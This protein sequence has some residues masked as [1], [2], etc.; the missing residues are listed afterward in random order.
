[1]ARL[2]THLLRQ[3]S[4]TCTVLPATLQAANTSA[5]WRVQAAGLRGNL[6]LTH[7]SPYAADFAYCVAGAMALACSSSSRK[8]SATFS[9]GNVRL[10]CRSPTRHEAPVTG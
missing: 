3:V 4:A 2:S 7:L 5:D 8:A 9:G 6:P 10:H 1:M